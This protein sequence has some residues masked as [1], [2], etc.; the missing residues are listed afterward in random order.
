[1]QR[2]DIPTSF[3][4]EGQRPGKDH[5]LRQSLSQPT[6]VFDLANP[7]RQRD[8][9]ELFLTEGRDTPLPERVIAWPIGTKYGGHS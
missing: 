2:S 9:I 8:T 7:S 6:T 4:P 5:I 1:M 3:R